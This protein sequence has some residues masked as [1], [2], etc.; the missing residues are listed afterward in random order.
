MTTAKNQV[1]RYPRRA[2]TASYLRTGAGLALLITPLIW[3][4]PGLVAGII[5]GSLALAFFSYGVRTWLRG[6]SRIQL[7]DEGVSIAGPLSQRSH[8][9]T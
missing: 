1:Y 3:G 2:L 4:N 7:D 8:G 5:L 6:I 9:E